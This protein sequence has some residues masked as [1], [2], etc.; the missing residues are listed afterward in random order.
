MLGFSASRE[1]QWMIPDRNPGEKENGKCRWAASGTNSPMGINAQ[2]HVHAHDQL[3]FL[4]S[5]LVTVECGNIQDAR[6]GARARDVEVGNLKLTARAKGAVGICSLAKS[7]FA[8][9]FA[10]FCSRHEKLVVAYTMRHDSG[11]C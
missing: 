11:R 8:R 7:A 9:V 4:L 1:F 3:P 6:R 2:R 10:T 5:G